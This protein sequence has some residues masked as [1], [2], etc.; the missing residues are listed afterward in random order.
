MTT[1]RPSRIIGYTD[2][3]GR[4]GKDELFFFASLWCEATVHERLADAICQVRESHHF[5]DVVHFSEMSNLRATVYQDVASALA[6]IPGW[7]MRVLVYEKRYDAHGRPYDFAH[8]GRKDE[9]PALKKARA[10]NKL[11]RDH[12]SSVVRYCPL[13][14]WQLYIEDR[15]RPRDDNGKDYIRLAL[16]SYYVRTVEFVPKTHHDLLQIVDLFLGAYALS[17][18]AKR[19]IDPKQPPGARKRQV[20]ETIEAEIRSHCVAPW[21]WQAR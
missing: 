7:T 11:L 2:E 16:Q 13:D 1:Q 6:L 18:Y 4:I 8:Y 14:F 17:M 19:G 20:A 10:Y 12:L 15:H 5:W 9:V 21:F 3:S